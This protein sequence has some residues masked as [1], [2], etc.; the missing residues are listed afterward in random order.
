MIKATIIADSVSKYTGQRITTFDPH[1]GEP[2][3]E[4][5]KGEYYE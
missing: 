4:L 1:T 2:I 5:P 3:T